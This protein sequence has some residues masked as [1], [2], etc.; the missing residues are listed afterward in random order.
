MLPTK[1]QIIWQSGFRG[2]DFQKSTNQKQ[3]LLV[4]AMFVNG[5]GRNEQSLQRTDHR[6][7][8]P[9]FGSFD[10]TVSEE[11]NSK[12][13]PI[14]NK[15]RLWWPCL[16]T[17]RDEMSN[18]YKGPSI[19]ASYQVSVHLAKQFQRRRF[20]KIVQSEIIVLLHPTKPKVV[21]LELEK[22]AEGREK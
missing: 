16:L 1:F 9:S 7:F 11:K 15:S 8:L 2:E 17:D 22:N 19:D 3:E 13:Q 4:A 21:I 14:R 18:I 10:Q 12:N 20:K 6:C 5:S